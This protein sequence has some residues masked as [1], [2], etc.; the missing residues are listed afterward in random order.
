[1]GKRTAAAAAYRRRVPAAAHL[2]LPACLPACLPAHPP[3]CAPKSAR[4]ANYELRA[5]LHVALV[6]EELPQ[7]ALVAR[8]PRAFA[9]AAEVDACRHRSAVLVVRSSPHP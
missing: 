6:V 2:P 3:A 5:G 9:K 7:L 8:V 4:A 1:M